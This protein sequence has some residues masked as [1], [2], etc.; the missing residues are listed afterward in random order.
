M[1]KPIFPS[2]Y[3]RITQGYN[4]G[5]HKDSYAIDNAGKDSGISD[6]Y[7]PFTGTI[8]KIYSTDANEVWL[9]STDKVEY[10]DG[11]Q[12]YMTILFAH[13][14]DVSNLFVGKK[15]VQKENFYKEG[16][17]GNVTGN[18]CHIECAKGKFTDSG[19]HKNASGYWS[20][21]NGKAPQECLWI[22]DTIKILDKHNYEFKKIS[23]NSVDKSIV[24]ETPT[25]EKNT[26]TE[27]TKQSNAKL[28]FTATKT[29]LY[30]VY[31][32]ENQKLII[33]ESP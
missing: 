13:A 10:P 5:T 24:E 21:N 18:H 27:D 25:V 3:M 23:T 12:D 11:T 14:N 20:I 16:T 19:W 6:I 26:T 31:L 32:K 7:A 8:K 4:E 29:D 1:E 9:E 30:G 28:E 2:E 33:E 15:I 17:K 22:D